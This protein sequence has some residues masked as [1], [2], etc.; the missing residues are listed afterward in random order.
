M[1]SKLAIL[2]GT[3]GHTFEVG[4]KYAFSDVCKTVG[5]IV[6]TQQGY[7]V[8]FDDASYVDVMSNN[9]LLFSE[10]GE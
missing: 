3:E 1:L 8:W 4:R 9:V 2:N 10:K 7:R 6:V 5:N